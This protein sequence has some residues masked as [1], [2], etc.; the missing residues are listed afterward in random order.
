MSNE[1]FPSLPGIEWNI[2]REPMFNTKVQRSANMN[3]VRASFASAPLYKFDLKFEFLRVD[4]AEVRLLLGFFMARF[5]SWDSFLFTANDDNAVTDEYF[6]TGDGSSTTFQ[7]RRSFGAFTET[8]SNVNATAAAPLIYVNNVLQTDI[9]DYAI[10]ATG[11]VTFVAAPGAVN[12]TWDGAYYYR[13]RFM[14]DAQQVSEFMQR[15]YNARS[16]SFIGSL[17]TKV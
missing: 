9:T 4:S 5:G 3:E 13:C 12:L 15:L 7:L 11:L 2:G 1:V 10:S 16:V 6:G 8:V 17:G 14:D